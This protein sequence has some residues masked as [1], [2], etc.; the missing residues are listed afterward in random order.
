[1]EMQNEGA[2]GEVLSATRLTV[3]ALHASSH[4]FLRGTSDRWVVAATRGGANEMY[5]TLGL[6]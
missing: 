5:M 3:G 2:V 1:M 6:S 4:W